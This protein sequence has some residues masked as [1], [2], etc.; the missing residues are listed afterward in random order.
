ML[1]N[2]WSSGIDVY[3]WLDSKKKG[4]TFSDKEKRN[5]WVTQ[6]VAFEH[7]DEKLDEYFLP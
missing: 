4:P 6:I 1:I 7:G 2:S 5:E 3:I